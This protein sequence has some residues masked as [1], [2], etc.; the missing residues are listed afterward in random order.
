MNADRPSVQPVLS[1][2]LLGPTVLVLPAASSPARD[3][4]APSSCHSLS[5]SLPSSLPLAN[6]LAHTI[7]LAPALALPRMPLALGART[8]A[9]RSRRPLVDDVRVRL[10]LWRGGVRRFQPVLPVLCAQHPGLGT[11]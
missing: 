7:A 5:L 10:S 9:P 4:P 11:K 3:A 8:A 2:R 1:G 6:P